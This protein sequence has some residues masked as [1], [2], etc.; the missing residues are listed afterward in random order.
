MAADDIDEASQKLIRQLLQQ[1]ITEAEDLRNQ[2]SPAISQPAPVA[3]ATHLQPTRPSDALFEATNALL[4]DL[5]WMVQ[6]DRQKCMSH[7]P[8]VH[9]IHG[10]E[11]SL[12][13]WL[14]AIQDIRN[15][16]SEERAQEKLGG[17]GG[18]KKDEAQSDQDIDMDA[19][20]AQEKDKAQPNRNTDTTQQEEF[21]KELALELMQEDFRDGDDRGLS[22]LNLELSEDEIG[23]VSLINQLYKSL[24]TIGEIRNRMKR[25]A[26]EPEMLR[27][28]KRRKSISAPTP[29]KAPG[30]G[31][32]QHTPMPRDSRYRYRHDDPLYSRANIKSAVPLGNIDTRRINKAL[33]IG[34]H[35]PRN[36]AE[37][38]HLDV[39][40]QL[41]W[42]PLIYENMTIHWLEQPDGKYRAEIRAPRLPMPL[43]PVEDDDFWDP[44]PA[45]NTYDHI[46]KVN[47]K[48]PLP[49]KVG[50][51][52]WDLYRPVGKERG[53][54]KKTDNDKIG[55]EDKGNDQAKGKGKD[56][57][58]DKSPEPTSETSPKA[59]TAKPSEDLAVSTNPDLAPLEAWAM[60]IAERRMIQYKKELNAERELMKKVVF[61]GDYLQRVFLHFQQVQAMLPQT[62]RKLALLNRTFRAAHQH[63]TLMLTAF[64]GGVTIGDVLAGLFSGDQA[65][66]DNTATSGR[67]SNG[68]NAGPL[69]H[70][71]SGN[72]AGPLRQ[73][74]NGNNAGSSRQ[75][76]NGNSAGTS[77]HQ[78]N[79]ND[80][81]RPRGSSPDP[82]DEE[83]LPQE[84]FNKM[85]KHSSSDQK[86]E[87]KTSGGQYGVEFDHGSSSSSSLSPGTFEDDLNDD[88]DRTDSKMSSPE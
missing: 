80:S 24:P 38:L 78:S 8:W 21:D 65:N 48:L 35:L 57:D 29:S 14:L 39:E 71:S 63:P 46:R 86:E 70:Q 45:P 60:E 28:K 2:A 64:G 43:P 42:Y 49:K 83:L 40:D 10:M 85:E 33:I 4:A 36:K 51:N 23:G 18:S 52:L 34:K 72:N 75:R 20:T 5:R 26:P 32:F 1:D 25:A 66:G 56:I 37:A 17:T 30:C 88:D 13:E 44:P 82:R 68:I 59:D 22:T 58:K 9:G 55:D 27:S 12:D 19:T 11:S 69:P 61:V 76:S 77:R 16:L 53:T 31:P 7:G 47:G 41:L 15:E 62:Q 54:D 67:Q 3:D 81:R 79:R 73:P 50:G 87:D 74:S 84:L 6:E